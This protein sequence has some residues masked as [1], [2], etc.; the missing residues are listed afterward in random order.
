LIFF[1]ITY[2]NINRK[3]VT[4]NTLELTVDNSFSMRQLSL[5]AI[6]KTR[7]ITFCFYSLHAR[8]RFICTGIAYA[9]SLDPDQAQQNVG[10]HLRSKLF[11]QLILFL[12]NDAENNM[13]YQSF[14]ITIYHT[15]NI[16]PN[17][18]KN[19]LSDEW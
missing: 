4:K 6:G 18:V 11:D 3:I 1:T 14:E 10:L 2:D 15:I 13:Y 19:L 8:G 12:Q 9:N 5:H 7:Q 16:I 17:R